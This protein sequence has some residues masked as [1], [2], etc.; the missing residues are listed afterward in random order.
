MDTWATSSLTPQIAGGWQDDGELFARVAGAG[1]LAHAGQERVQQR[2]LGPPE[3][4]V[5][6][7]VQAGTGEHLEQRRLVPGEPHV[8]AGDRGQPRRGRPGAGQVPRGEDLVPAHRDRGEQLLPVG[9]V[10]VRGA[11][12]DAHA[13]AR[14]GEGEAAHAA[15]R[16]QLDRRV[17][18]RRAQVAVVIAAA[19]GR[20]VARAG[21]G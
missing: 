2:L 5:P 16:D 19:R 10:R 20:H 17:D 21:R 15:L 9:E 1:Q 6:L 12:G 4:R 13:P 18:Q 14:L 11:G 8:P 3:L 7:L